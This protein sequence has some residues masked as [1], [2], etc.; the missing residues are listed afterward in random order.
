VVINQKTTACHCEER[1][2]A[3]RRGNLSSLDCKSANAA[4]VTLDCFRD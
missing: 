3:E 2:E 1:G 4:S